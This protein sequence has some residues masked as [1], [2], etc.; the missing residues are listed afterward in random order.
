MTSSESG[1]LAAVPGS[2]AS[3]ATADGTHAAPRP[4]A[5]SI[6][7]HAALVR[8]L[9]RLRAG[10]HAKFMAVVKAGAF[11]HGA[12]E[13]ARTALAAGAEWLG[14]ATLEEALEL[15]RAGISAPI[16]VWLIDPWCDL[17]A[18]IS[19]GVTLSCANLETL[20]AVL[21]ATTD[22]GV[23]A[24]IQLELDTGMARAGATDAAWAELCA[25]AAAAESAGSARV[26]GVWSHFALASDP[27]PEGVRSAV[28]AFEHGLAV[29][30]GA[31]LDPEEVH[32]ANSAATL[33]HPETALTMVRCG[34]SLYGIE[35]VTGQTHGLEPALRLVT[36]VTQLRRIRAGAGVGYDHRFVTARDTTIVLL[37]VGYADGVPRVLGGRAEVMIGGRR[38][39]MVGVVSM[40]QVTVDVGDAEVALGD[41]VVLLGDASRGEPDAAEWARLASTLSHEILTGLGGR[42]SRRHVNVL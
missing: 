6:I 7:D 26:S 39:P 21:E 17:A 25:A 33:A 23:A 3:A 36:R 42:I 2:T 37:P 31:G 1:P 20:A 11:G 29:A 9:R 8:N 12:V 19:A 4:L 28:A 15:R 10:H 34:A 24:Q 18:G 16:L 5:E 35:T 32:L 27:G 22:A 14:V 13:T 30:R 40:D 38:Y 41:E